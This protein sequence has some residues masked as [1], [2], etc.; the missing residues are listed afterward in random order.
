MICFVNNQKGILRPE[1]SNS[2]HQL[3]YIYIYMI[4][5]YK[6]IELHRL[7]QFGFLDLLLQVTQ[8]FFLSC[9]TIS[10]IK[11]NDVVISAVMK[12]YLVITGLC[13]W[14]MPRGWWNPTS[15]WAETSLL[16]LNEDEWEEKTCWPFFFWSHIS[17]SCLSESHRAAQYVMI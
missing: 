17:Q 12:T 2:A 1:W 4:Y 3:L 13:G 16:E 7:F 11:P 8:G 15:N 9:T 10:L 5:S 6:L 14:F